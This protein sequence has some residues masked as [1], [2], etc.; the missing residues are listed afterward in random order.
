MDIKTLKISKHRKDTAIISMSDMKIE[1][2]PDGFLLE[3][4]LDAKPE[5]RYEFTLFATPI[6]KAT[7]S[8]PKV[9]A[10][11]FVNVRAKKKQKG[12]ITADSE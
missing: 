9:M 4:A 1:D 3:L 7:S 6:N 8:D 2:P 12:Q 10:H 5:K 11:M